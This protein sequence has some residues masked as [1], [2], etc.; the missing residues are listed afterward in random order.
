M[1]RSVQVSEWYINLGSSLHMK[2]NKD[3]FS[4]LVEKDM[5]FHIELGDYGS[6]MTKG[7]GTVSFNRESSFLNHL[8]N[9]MYVPGLKKNLVSVRILKD[10]GYDVVFNKGK[11][12]LKHY[13]SRKVKKN[14]VRIRNLYKF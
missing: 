5:Q 8:K 1:E 6:Y 7:V 4:I 3:F 10:K 9:V 11:A 13:S 2:G 12:Y 14:G